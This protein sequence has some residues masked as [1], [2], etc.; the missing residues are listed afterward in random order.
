MDEDEDEDEDGEGATGISKKDP[1]VR[2]S[3]LLLKSGLA[4]VNS[5]SEMHYNLLFEASILL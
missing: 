1:S 5:I 3:E 4:K 2:R